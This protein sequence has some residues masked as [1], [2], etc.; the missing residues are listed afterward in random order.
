MSLRGHSK[1]GWQVSTSSCPNGMGCF[2]WK[3]SSHQPKLNPAAL[4]T[5]MQDSLGL[6]SGYTIILI[7]YHIT[8]FIFSL[9]E[10]LFSNNCASNVLI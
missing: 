5:M 4:K 1:N 2:A 9:P 8:G 7:T 10:K 3:R 6:E